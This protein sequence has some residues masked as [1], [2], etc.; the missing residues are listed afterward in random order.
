MINSR[1][2]YRTK[3]GTIRYIGPVHNDKNNPER[4][5]LGIEWDKDGDGLHDGSVIID[6]DTKV[7]RRYFTCPSGRGSFVKPDKVNT[8]ISFA[9]AYAERY[10]DHFSTTTTAS[11]H[12][13]HETRNDNGLVVATP[14]TISASDLKIAGLAFTNLGLAADDDDNNR[15]EAFDFL[16]SLDVSDTLFD[17]WRNLL[18]VASRL[19]NL[20]ILV[21]SDN[22]ALSEGE[23]H[24]N[25]DR[26]KMNLLHTL[27]LTRCGPKSFMIVSNILDAPLLL[28]SL[29]LVSCELEEIPLSIPDSVEE[30]D[31]SFNR[32][33]KL[34][35]TEIEKLPNEIVTLILNGNSALRIIIT[36][37]DSNNHNHIIKKCQK[38]GKICFDDTNIQTWKEVEVMDEMFPNLGDLRLWS[39]PLLSSKDL[40]IQNNRAR[41]I[42]R[43]PQLIRLNGT[44]ISVTERTDAE[45]ICLKSGEPFPSQDIL[46]KKYQF[47]I[48][49]RKR[50]SGSTLFAITMVHR[51][52]SVIRKIPASTRLSNVLIVYNRLF[53]GTLDKRDVNQLK[54]EYGEALDGSKHHVVTLEMDD[55]LTLNDVIPE[56]ATNLIIRNDA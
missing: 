5:W 37:A 25:N 30:L 56:N 2:R 51:S 42:V 39:I 11:R 32:L 22:S 54:L 24:D 9:Q 36:D 4:I 49:S 43:F 28:K 55:R 44:E 48:V 3:R 10:D 50:A 27:A 40:G 8:P 35:R 16:E 26:F 21:A 1:V 20:K 31:L 13:H 15:F 34:D 47:D 12:H 45:I 52:T 38:M 7:R 53:A 41:I 6:E 17:S 29:H 19:K 14:E 33:S 46:V 23:N 18:K